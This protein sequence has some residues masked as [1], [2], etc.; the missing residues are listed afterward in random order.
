MARIN[1]STIAIN[2]RYPYFFMKPQVL[3]SVAFLILN[4][5]LL[6]GWAPGWL[7]GKLSDLCGLYFAPIFLCALFWIFSQRKPTELPL[8]ILIL[9]LT[10]V[11]LVF[12]ALKLS[13]LARDIYLS[14]YQSIGLYVR[15]TPDRTDLFCVAIQVFYFW[16]RTITVR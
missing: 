2:F 6:K 4:D 15:V 12:V 1:L 7:T 3:F 16:P 9:S 11:D 5:H 10:L 8:K 14:L 13:P